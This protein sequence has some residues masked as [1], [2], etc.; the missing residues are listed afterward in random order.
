MRRRLD[1]QL[2]GGEGQQ[3]EGAATQL[4]ALARPQ[5]GL[6]LAAPSYG[7][8]QHGG[9]ATE[10]ELTQAQP[11][12][13]HLRRAGALQARFTAMAP[14]PAGFHIGQAGLKGLGQGLGL[15]Q[16]QQGGGLGDAQHLLGIDRD[17]IGALQP[18]HPETVRWHQAKNGTD[19][20]I[21]M[22]PQAA[23]GTEVGYRL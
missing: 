21:H 11:E 3:V 12:L 13:E 23:P 22:Q 19:R 5:Q 20:P 6:E 4:Q 10:T 15:G 2:P 17:R 8:V 14:A 9:D 1:I 18:G 7:P 16:Q